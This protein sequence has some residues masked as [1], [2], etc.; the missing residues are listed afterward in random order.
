MGAGALGARLRAG[1]ALAYDGRVRVEKIAAADVSG[2]AFSRDPGSGRRERVLVEASAGG[3]DAPD[4]AAFE[5]YA[6]DRRTGRELVPRAGGGASP[7]LSAER[8][9][10]VAK[11]ARA[12]DS[13]KGSGVE[14][15]FSF[16]GPRLL[17]H[18]A[19]ALEAPRP[20]V[21][22]AD[23]FAPRVE[24]DQFLNVRPVGR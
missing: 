2:V 4:G 3:L 21:P 11:L 16:A 19:R 18:H 12:L 24:A 9:A 14:V 1:R 22:L 23:P 10:R 6:L 5:A 8:L 15:A 7:L 20:I 13:W 17:V